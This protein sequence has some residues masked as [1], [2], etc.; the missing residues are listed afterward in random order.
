[1][2]KVIRG[3]EFF[4]VRVLRAYVNSLSEHDALRFG[5]ALGAAALRALGTRASVVRTNL[6]LCGVLFPAEARFRLFLLRCFQ[7]IGITAAEILRLGAYRGSDFRSKITCH[8][9]ALF[10]KVHRMRRGAVLMSGHIGNWE[11]LG[12]YVARLGYP[13]DLLVRRQSNREVDTLM[14]SLRRRQR[15]GIIYT[16]TGA[17]TL[18]EAIRKGRFVAILADQYGGAK[19]EKVWFFGNSVPVPTGPAAL[20]HKYDLPLVF[21]A[22]RR[23]KNGRHLLEMESIT[24][25]SNHDRHAIAQKYTE[26]LEAAVRRSPEMWLWTHRKFKNLTDY[27][28]IPR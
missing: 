26:L 9:I 19:S 17:R 18:V 4:A 27:G 25:W 1:M 23:M 12:G 20:M 6:D 2:R 16:D 15:V 28:S 24:D 13:V 7:H 22:L 14:N 10:S 11:L 8:R 5:A 3:I 21:G